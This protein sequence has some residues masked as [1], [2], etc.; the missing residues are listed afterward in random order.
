[1]RVILIGYMGSGKSS[2]GKRVA[3]AL[4]IPFI[5]SDA[6]ISRITGK[7]TSEIFEQEGEN[8]FRTLEK[9]LIQSLDPT[10]SFVL[11]T[12]GGLP[13]FNNLMAEL[14]NLGTTIYLKHSPQNLAKRL[15]VSKTNRPLILN[16][17]AAGTLLE[18]IQDHL[19]SREMI[20][21]QAHLIAPSWVVKPHQLIDFAK[22]NQ[23]S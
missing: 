21:N 2:L 9:K 6:E 15:S 8:H 22:L 14:N 18:F 4:G 1:M 10:E 7:S 5:D 16:H 20:Y 17:I 3:R 12:G 13:C 11:A 23:K 19:I